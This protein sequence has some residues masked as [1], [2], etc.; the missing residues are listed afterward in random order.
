MLHQRLYSVVA[1]M[2]APAQTEPGVHP[3]EPWVLPEAVL[4]PTTASV[5][6]GA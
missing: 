2:D 1:D 6:Q 5:G 4:M 3:G